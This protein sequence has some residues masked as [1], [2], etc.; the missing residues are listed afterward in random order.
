MVWSSSVLSMPKSK[1]KPSFSAVGL[2]SS[3][4]NVKSSSPVKPASS[5]MSKSKVDVVSDVVSN[6]SASKSSKLN[7]LSLN[8]S[9]L[10]CATVVCAMGCCATGC[11]LPKSR[12]LSILPAL[13]SKGVSSSDVTDW[14]DG[15]GLDSD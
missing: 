6:K 1:S 14:T 4:S 7:A 11:S 10:V 8:A 5:L 3:K 15:S 12:A 2:L 9:S 13:K